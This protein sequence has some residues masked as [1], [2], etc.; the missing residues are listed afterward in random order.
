MTVVE[1][2]GNDERCREIITR[3]RWPKGVR[4]LRCHSDKVSPHLISDRKVFVCYSCRYQFSPTVGTIFHDSHLPLTAWFLVTQLMTR[5]QKGISA[6]QVK[7]ILGVSYKTAWYLC[8]RIR[9]AMGEANARRLDSAVL[10]DE[11]S[12]GGRLQSR[13]RCRRVPWYEIVIGIGKRNGDH[14]QLFRADDLRSNS[15]AKCISESGAADLDVAVIDRVRRKVI[16]QGGVYV[17]GFRCNLTPESAVSLL[18]REITDTW[19]KIRAKHLPSYLEETAFRF[20]NRRNPDRFRNALHKLI[21][22]SNLEY[23]A[24]TADRVITR[25]EKTTSRAKRE[26]NRA[27]QGKAQT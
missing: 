8:H 5:S 20:N 4:C 25:G 12:V 14:L 9:K 19:R 3:L 15:L 13:T 27:V 23:K 7:Q 2:Y 22:S 16:A 11:T 18:E 10:V 26:R 24:L 17:I 21:A 6:N 1:R